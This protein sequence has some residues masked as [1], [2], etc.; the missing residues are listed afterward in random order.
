MR[1][2]PEETDARVKKKIMGWREFTITY[3]VLLL[4]VGIQVGIIVLPFFERIHAF[5]QIN[6]VMVYWALV[7]FSFSFIT[8]RQIKEKYDRPMRILGGAAKQVAGGDFSVYVEPV[9]TA[10]NYDYIDVMFLDFNTMVQ[11]L[12]SIETLK[13][14]FVANVS[15]EIK[16]PLAVIRNYTTALG[17]EALPTDMRKEYIDTIVKATD[18]LTTLVTNILR[19]N[20]LENQEIETT[21]EPYNLCRQLY[22]CALQF[23]SLW[24]EKKI[25]FIIDVEDR[26]VITADR[27]MLE[28]VWNNLLS[29]ALKYTEPGGKVSLVQTSDANRITVSVSDAGCGM[30]EETIKHIFDKF[31]Q[32]DTSHS[33][34][35]NGLGL[36]LA[37]RIIEKVRGTLTVTSAPGKGSTFTV[38]IPLAG[39]V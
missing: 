20:K 19:L 14:D 1:R 35:G 39:D 17:N 4:L 13:N 7:A 33:G 9:H 8:N 31:Y 3:T 25:E 36:T 15:H 38:M 26:A 27:E 37:L 12:G 32:A 6:I 5:F 10:D 30:D 24:D 16:T 22:D 21:A 18:N 2:R 28:I 29:N 11:E 23:E 34:E